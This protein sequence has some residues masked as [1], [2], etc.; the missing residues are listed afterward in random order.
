MR[1][2][3]QTLVIQRFN[4]CIFVLV[5]PLY[6]WLG[7]QFFVCLFVCFFFAYVALPLSLKIMILF[8]TFDGN[9]LGT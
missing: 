7:D 4:V 3:K 6:F 1:V 9:K 8:V 5:Y 2:H